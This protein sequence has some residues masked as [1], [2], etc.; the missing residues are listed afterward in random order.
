MDRYKDVIKSGGEWI[1]D[2]II[3]FLNANFAKWQLPDDLLFVDEIPK[4]SVGKFN[5]KEIRHI[6][7]EHYIK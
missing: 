4:T 6:Y 1:S 3:A 2:E 7:R 5:K